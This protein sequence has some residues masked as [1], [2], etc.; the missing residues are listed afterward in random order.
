[1]KKSILVM[2]VT[3][4]LVVSFV[5]PISA[6]SAQP[7]LDVSGSGNTV[8]LRVSTSS[9]YG[10]LQGVITYDAEKLTYKGATVVDGLADSYKSEKAIKENE[11]GKITVALIGDVRNGTAGEWFTL[12]FEVKGKETDVVTFAFNSVKASSIDGRTST[13]LGNTT[14]DWAVNSAI[15]DVNGDGKVDVRDLI[16]FKKYS[17]GITGTFIAANADCNGDGE[18]DAAVDIIALKK[19]LLGVITVF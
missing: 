8:E 19:I 2:V 7:E 10:G 13:V 15:G 3:L 18:L 14:I 11:T 5:M 9:V 12:E 6:T 1:M 17:A 16:C 4:M